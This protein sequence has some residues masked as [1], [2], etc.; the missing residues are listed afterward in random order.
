MDYSK[1]FEYRPFDIWDTDPYIEMCYNLTCEKLEKMYPNKNL[2][3]SDCFGVSIIDDISDS[4]TEI[5]S[6]T[7]GR[8]GKA[9]PLAMRNELTREVNILTIRNKVSLTN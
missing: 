6:Y 7:T 9:G 1:M 4:F 8:L 3:S 2:F 5:V